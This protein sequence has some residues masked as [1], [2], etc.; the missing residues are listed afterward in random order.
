MNT[1]TPGDLPRA[2]RVRMHIYAIGE[3]HQYRGGFVEDLPGEDVEVFQATTVDHAVDLIEKKLGEPIQ[4]QCHMIFAPLQEFISASKNSRERLDIFC[5]NSRTMLIGGRNDNH[6]MAERL[7]FANLSYMLP[8]PFDYREILQCIRREL[9]LRTL[10]SLAHFTN[11]LLSGLGDAI[12]ITDP[13]DNIVWINDRF[14]A[15]TGYELREV[16]GKRPNFMR[17]GKNHDYVFE[18]MWRVLTA[19]GMWRGEIWNRKKSGE[20]YAEW[21]SVCALNGVAGKVDGYVSILADITERKIREEDLARQALHDVLTGLPNRILLQ[22]RFELAAN[23]RQNSNLSIDVVFLDL[24]GFKAANDTYGHALGDQVLVQVGE[25]L[26]EVV[27]PKNTV[28]RIGGDEFVCLF[29]EQVKST[30]ANEKVV[31]IKNIMLQPFNIDGF[32][33]RL[34]CSIGISTFPI[35]GRNLSELL[36]IADQRMYEEK[37]S[38]ETKS[39]TN[40]K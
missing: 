33:V 20:V 25:R 27:G 37:L 22:D 15:L 40:P 36:A 28:A 18:E 12:M 30:T 9:E 39:P 16:R 32:A 8:L 21:L 38:R 2:Q 35:D 31:A 7:S 26:A 3:T 6:A 4:N 11:A 19:S 34:N 5:K 13:E 1:F 10:K 23:S 17:A 24:D 29:V 14:T